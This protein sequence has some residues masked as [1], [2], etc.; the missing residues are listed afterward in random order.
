MINSRAAE[1]TI[2]TNIENFIAARGTTRKH[3]FDRARISRQTFDRAMS[4]GRSFT[5][6]EIVSIAEALTV[7]PNQLLPAEWVNS[8]QQAA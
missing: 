1:Q 2:I 4:G 6:E 8:A 7:T 3:V 5:V